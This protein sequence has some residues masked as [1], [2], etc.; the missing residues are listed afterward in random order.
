MIKIVDPQKVIDSKVAKATN[1][2]RTASSTYR[3][4]YFNLNWNI[5]DRFVLYSMQT[6]YKN[7]VHNAFLAYIGIAKSWIIIL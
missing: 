1:L 7:T 4:T 3:K 2:A 6:K 5:L